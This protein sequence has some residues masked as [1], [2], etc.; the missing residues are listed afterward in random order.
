MLTVRFKLNEHEILK[1]FNN[2]K[3]IID[4]VRQK[5]FVSAYVQIVIRHA[6]NVDF[7]IVNQQLN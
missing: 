6:K 2:D 5:K 4:D 7:I 1:F 3:F